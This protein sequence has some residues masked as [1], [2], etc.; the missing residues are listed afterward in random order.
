VVV[1][2]V[3]GAGVGG[4]GCRGGMGRGMGLPPGKTLIHCAPEVPCHCII[5]T[6]RFE[7]T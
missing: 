4:G 2:A 1:V 5:D 6:E 3:V 7:P